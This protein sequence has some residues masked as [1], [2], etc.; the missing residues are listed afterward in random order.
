MQ[1]TLLYLDQRCLTTI[2]QDSHLQGEMHDLI[3]VCARRNIE[4]IFEERS[5]EWGVDTDFSPDFCR[6]MKE[7]KAGEAKE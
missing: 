4:V 7:K 2:G 5:E 3:E 1:L 6:R